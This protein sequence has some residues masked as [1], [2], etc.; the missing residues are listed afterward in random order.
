MSLFQVKRGVITVISNV[1]QDPK[2]INYEFSILG[3]TFENEYETVNEII[4]LRD[5][6]CVHIVPQKLM[7]RYLL[8]EFAYLSDYKQSLSVIL[9]TCFNV[10]LQ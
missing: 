10:N 7:S 4:D 5:G 9:R 3:S 6:W 2:N 1:D 8:S